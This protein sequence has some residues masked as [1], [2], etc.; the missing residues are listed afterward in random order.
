VSDY[1]ERG[2]IPEALVNYL[3]LLGWNPGEDRE[4][5]DRDE[6]ISRFDLNR[7]I[8]SG[9]MFDVKKLT[10]FNA[11]HL[12]LLSDGE[13]VKRLVPLLIENK[14]IAAHPDA[15][16]LSMLSQLAAPLKERMTLLPDALPSLVPFFR[17]PEPAL[18]D[19]VQKKTDAATTASGLLAARESLSQIDHWN[20]ANI[21]S[22]LKACAQAHPISKLLYMALRVAI[23]GGTV[24]LPMTD[25]LAVL[26]RDQCLSRIDRAIATISAQ[27]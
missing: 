1:L 4:I 24:S 22:A 8:P 7:L 25:T 6:L 20:V 23:T 14:V 26:G 21:D 9:G 5:M 27:E 17:T 19:L 16:T 13:L 15:Q 10:S 2:F 12:R 11:Q 18:A 3:C